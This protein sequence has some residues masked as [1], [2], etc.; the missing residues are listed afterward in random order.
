MLYLPLKFEVCLAAGFSVCLPGWTA[1]AF[2]VQ[3]NRLAFK[4]A[5][6]VDHV[7]YFLPETGAPV[8]AGNSLL[9]SHGIWFD[10]ANYAGVSYRTRLFWKRIKQP[11]PLQRTASV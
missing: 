6:R 2:F 11:L 7:V 4:L 5:G 3:L 1:A 10:H 9:I 8:V